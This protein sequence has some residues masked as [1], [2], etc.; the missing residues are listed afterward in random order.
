MLIC[1]G[2]E[3]LNRIHVYLLLA[4]EGTCFWHRAEW[5]RWDI[6]GPWSPSFYITSY[7]E[8]ATSS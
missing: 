7:A 2:R 6:H 8:A 1:L 4:S 5:W 3:V